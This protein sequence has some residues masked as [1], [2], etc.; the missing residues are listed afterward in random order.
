M[1]LILALKKQRQRQ[2]DLNLTQNKTKQNKTKQKTALPT[3]QSKK[4]QSFPLKPMETTSSF[5]RSGSII[6]GE[7]MLS[8]TRAQELIPTSLPERSLLAM[9]WTEQARLPHLRG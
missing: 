3:P 5:F 2:A 8:I 6:Q 4:A 7:N 9:P 1:P